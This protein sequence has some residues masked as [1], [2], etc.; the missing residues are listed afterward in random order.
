MVL[1]AF[2]RDTTESM[3]VVRSGGIVFRLLLPATLQPSK[4]GRIRPQEWADSG[5]T[6]RGESRDPSSRLTPGGAL[7]GAEGALKP[8]RRSNR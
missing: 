8:V 4:P 6:A 3:P 7:R 2:L 1:A 5:R